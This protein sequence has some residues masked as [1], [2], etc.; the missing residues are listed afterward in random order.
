MCGVVGIVAVHPVNQLLYNALLLMQHRGQD[1]AG[2]ATAQGKR[3]HLSRGTGLVRDVFR[4][5]DMRNLA[6]NMGIGHVRYP[7]AGS[8]VS[9]EEA[10]PFYVNAPFGIV[11][12]HNG[13]LTNAAELEEDMYRRDRRHINT[14]SD[15]EVLLNVFAHE[16]QQAVSGLTLDPDAVFAAVTVLQ[17]RAKGAYACVAMIPGFG[18]IGFRD[19]YGIRPLVLGARQEGTGKEHILASESVALEGL[20]F[21]LVRDIAPGECIVITEEQEVFSKQCSQHSSLNPCVFEFVYFARPDSQI[22]GI[23]VY[24]AR[25]KMGETLAAEVKASF[26]AGDIDVVIPIPESS[27]PAALQLAMHLNVPYREGFIKNRYVGRTFIMPGQEIRKQSVRQKL[28]AM[29][30]E[31][32]GKRVLIVDDSIVRGTTSREIVSMARESGARGVIFASAA[33]P[34]RFPNVYGIDMPSR[35]ELIAHGRTDDEICA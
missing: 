15:S 19:P 25:L 30:S 17:R 11:L 16:L 3:I 22:D 2:I 24:D 9:A 28:N 18:V 6:G 8:A 4:T 5:R 23:S 7:T 13:N 1:A 29:A 27:R 12:G 21:E 35:R 32:K 10:Q 26:P 34:V 33:P 14:E 31:F 20:G